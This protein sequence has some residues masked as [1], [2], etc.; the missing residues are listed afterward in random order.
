MAPKDDHSAQT[1]LTMGASHIVDAI[2]GLAW[3][4]ATDGSAEFFNGRWYEY[5]GLSPE[6]SSGWGWKVAVHSDDLARLPDQLGARDAE[7]GQGC[8]VRLRRFDGAFQWFLLRH[9]P[10]R[11]S[12]GA[13]VRWYGT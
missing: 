2:P 9:E 10:L 7:A 8:E 12:S 6:A 1:T 3:S 13:V 4:G 5:T 11:D